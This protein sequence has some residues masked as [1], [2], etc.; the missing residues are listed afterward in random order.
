MYTNGLV[1]IDNEIAEYASLVNRIKDLEAQKDVIRARIIARME[2][3]KIDTME[4]ERYRMTYMPGGGPRFDTQAF[5]TAYPKLYE[6]FRTKPPTMYLKYVDKMEEKLKESKEPSKKGTP[7]STTSR[8]A[9]PQSSP[10]RRNN[11]P[12]NSSTPPTRGEISP[13][14]L[15]GR[16]DPPTDLM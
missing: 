13:D 11:P 9:K 6:E 14:M 5:K 15:F 12:K 8:P 3:A 2:A 1:A 4:G 7:K 10:P 16:F